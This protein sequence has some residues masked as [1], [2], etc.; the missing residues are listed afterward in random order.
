MAISFFKICTAC[1]KKWV[2]QAL[3][4]V[5]PAI[6]LVGYQVAFEAREAGYLL[7][8]HNCGTTLAVAVHHFYDLPHSLVDLHCHEKLSP[9]HCLNED[10]EQD[11]QAGCECS[12]VKKIMKIIKLWPKK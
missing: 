12:Q 2:N 7:F 8:N 5:D 6:S 4:L 1:G 10:G 9:E 3:F 11:C